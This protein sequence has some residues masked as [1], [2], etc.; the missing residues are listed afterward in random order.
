MG[1]Q[2]TLLGANLRL[3]GSLGLFAELGAG[4]Q[5]AVQAGLNVRF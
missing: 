1:F 3:A 2:V 4:F 5:G